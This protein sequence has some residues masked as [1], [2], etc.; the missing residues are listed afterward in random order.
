MA[1]WTASLGGAMLLPRRLVR[2][3]TCTLPKQTGGETDELK[4]PR[5]RGLS[6]QHSQWDRT[7]RYRLVLR[8]Q[9]IKRGVRL[10]GG[11]RWMPAWLQR[12]SGLRVVTSSVRISS[13]STE[14]SWPFV[15][16]LAS[17]SPL[18]TPCPEKFHS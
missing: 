9:E 1:P 2:Y 16:L 6:C 7:I 3:A 10:V 18:G 8:W 4:V 12:D 14:L 13:S 11:R 15:Q 17:P 5:L